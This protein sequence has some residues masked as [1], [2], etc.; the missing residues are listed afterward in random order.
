MREEREMAHDSWYVA[1]DGTVVIPAG[2]TPC[3]GLPDDRHY[4]GCPEFDEGALDDDRFSR[5]AT[6]SEAHAEWHWNAGV[7]MH[8]GACPWDCCGPADDHYG[9]TYGIG[10]FADP[11]LPVWEGEPRE[12]G[13]AV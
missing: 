1:D 13:A 10:L 11:G 5:T 8:T 9:E 2:C 3:C 4:Y 6:E 12:F 7:P